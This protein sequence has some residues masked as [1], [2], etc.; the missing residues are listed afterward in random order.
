MLTVDDY[1]LIRR[2]YFIDGMS[3]RQIARELGHGRETVA[4]AIEHALPPRYRLRQPR[5]KPVIEEVS[6]IIEAWLD[7]DKTRPR[8]QRHTAQRIYERLRDEHG[9]TGHA[10]TVR[11]YVASV[12]NRRKD[13]FFPLEFEPGQEAQVDWHEGQA[14]V[15]GQQRKLQFFCMR[16]CHSKASFVWA[17]ERADLISFLDGHVRALAYFGGVPHRIAYDN[18]KSAVIQVM[19]GKER[20]LNERFIE[21]RRWLSP[22][23]RLSP[24][25]YDCRSYVRPLTKGCEPLMRS[26]RKPAT[27][28]GLSV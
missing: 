4:K 9:F 3:R 13:V 24:V 27:I 17:Y 5:G 18:L 20:R 10:S 22:F 21:L 8:K 15:N 14:V 16:L 12:K 23:S 25:V 6:G 28:A 7:Q 19:H 1:E 2:K 11:R 26:A